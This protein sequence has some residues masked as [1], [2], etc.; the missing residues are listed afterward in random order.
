MPRRCLT[1]I[2]ACFVL[3]VAAQAQDFSARFWLAGLPKNVTGCLAFD[4]QFTREHTLTVKDGKATLTSP[5]GIDTSLSLVRPGVYE[6][7]NELGGLQL[8]I[9]ADINDKTLTVSD[10]YIGCWWTAQWD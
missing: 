3:P 1:F 6:E 10:K 8:K 9:V 4:P 7:D 5:G 2:V